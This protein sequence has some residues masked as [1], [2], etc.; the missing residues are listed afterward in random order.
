MSEENPDTKRLIQLAKLEEELLS[1]R[2]DIYPCIKYLMQFKDTKVT[3]T[4]GLN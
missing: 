3:V 2:K 1:K 4:V